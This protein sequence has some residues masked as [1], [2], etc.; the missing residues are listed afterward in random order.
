MKL[1]IRR[2]VALA[3]ISML[4]PQLSA[5]LGNAGEFARNPILDAD[6]PDITVIRVAEACS[7][8]C[9]KVHAYGIMPNH[10][11]VPSTADRL[12]PFGRDA[13]ATLG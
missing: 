1:L 4:L 12:L 10:L 9:R 6:V 13:A 5:Q 3:L 2:L 11:P 8:T 7:K